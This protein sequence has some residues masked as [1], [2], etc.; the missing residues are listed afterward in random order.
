MN[1]LGFK[2]QMNTDIRD[3][4][5]LEFRSV[6]LRVHLWPI[7]TKYGPVVFAESSMSITFQRFPFYLFAGETV[8]TVKV[9]FLLSAPG[10]R[11]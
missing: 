10:C 11:V 2:P 8:K 7:M 4:N 9:F 1:D 5:K 6:L 3:L